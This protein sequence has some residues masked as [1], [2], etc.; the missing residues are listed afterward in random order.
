MVDINDLVLLNLADN[1]A[2]NEASNES[3]NPENILKNVYPLTDKWNLSYHVNSNRSFRPS[4]FI[5]KL[6]ISN[7]KEFWEFHNNLDKVGM[8]KDS[9]YYIMRNGITPTRED[10][11]NRRGR[12]TSIKIPEEIMHSTWV[13]LAALVMGET[14][15]QK[16]YL[17]NGIHIKYVKDNRK[18]RHST[19][20]EPFALIKIMAS[21]T[22]KDVNDGIKAFLAECIPAYI[23]PKYLNYK[24]S[25]QIT[26]IVPEY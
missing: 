2:S 10:K 12:I 18:N 4:D 14:F 25:V 24:Y 17:V 9:N 7:L 16:N 6:S 1:K 26:N 21:S 15:C 8:L 5:H 3:N 23:N 22:D 11:K 13:C 20:E 19:G